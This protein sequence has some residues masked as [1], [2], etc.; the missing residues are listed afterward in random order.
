MIQQGTIVPTN[1]IQ[2][3]GVRRNGF[4]SC[5]PCWVWVLIA[6]VILGAMVGGL[7]ALLRPSPTN[8]EE[9]IQKAAEY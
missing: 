4:L 2:S 9:E 8:V 6:L 7:F 1:I 3:Q 5:C